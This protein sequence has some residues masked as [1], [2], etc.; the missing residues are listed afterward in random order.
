M[1]LRY[2]DYATI[3]FQLIGDNLYWPYWI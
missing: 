2:V 3:K 1:T